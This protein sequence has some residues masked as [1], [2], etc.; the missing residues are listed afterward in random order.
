MTTKALRVALL[1]LL[2]LLLPLRGAVA[3][4]MSCALPAGVVVQ[5]ADHDPAAVHPTGHGHDEPATHHASA[6][7]CHLCVAAGA[8]TPLPMDPPRLP[9]AAQCTTLRFPPLAEAVTAFVPEGPERPPRA[10]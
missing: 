1:L 10:G 6:D 2:A 8:A 3:A 9:A 4:S 5:V 7:K